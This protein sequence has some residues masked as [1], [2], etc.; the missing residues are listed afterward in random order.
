ME[1]TSYLLEEEE[2]LEACLSAIEPEEM[3]CHDLLVQ[4]F[5]VSMTQEDFAR[6]SGLIKASFPQAKVIGGKVDVCISGGRGSSNGISLTFMKFMSSEAN[7][8]VLHLDDEERAIEEDACMA[9]LEKQEDLAAIQVLTIGHISAMS[10]LFGGKIL[11][12]LFG[13][14]LGDSIGGK[15]GFIYC[16]GEVLKH[17]LLLVALC[18]PKLRVQVERS[19]GWQPLGPLMTITRVNGPYIVSELDG[20]P[21]EVMYDHYIGSVAGETFLD[22]SLLFPIVLH[23][24]S[25][26]I[27]RH[28]LRCREDGSAE[29]GAGFAVGDLV[30]FGYGNPQHV[31]YDT[32]EMQQRIAEFHP[33][34]L[35]LADCLAR[36]LLMEGNVESELKNC[37]LIAPSFGFYGYGELM[38]GRSSMILH[39]MTLVLTGI[40][41]EDTEELRPKARFV[42]DHIPLTR[43]QQYLSHLV[44]FVQQTTS[45]LEALNGLLGHKAQT[46][47]LT[48]L[49]N[50]GQIESLLQEI[51]KQE[52]RSPRGVCL[53]MIDAD[54]FKHINDHFGHDT[55]DVALKTIADV[56]KE[57]VR[58]SDAV[59]RWGGDEFWVILRETDGEGAAHVAARIKAGLAAYH[60]PDGTKYSLSIGIAAAIKGDTQETFFRRADQALYQAKRTPGKNATVVI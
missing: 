45:E 15:E 48:G 5:S 28:P 13:G 55:G 39:N 53:M 37:R 29:F 46:D 36:W 19:S 23:R 42:P 9:W 30:Q 54:N 1:V 41:E 4:I 31:I 43:Q 40:R 12:P 38:H 35:F 58:T 24:E 8:C 14:L 10:E 57:Q 16:D 21:F 49:Y 18:G 44:H 50:K 56:L 20:Q 47:A 17:G 59:G 33:Q 11:V 27:A 26:L 22:K 6:V 2:E 7:L 32:Q 60:L 25:G 51:M 3:E 52:A 34:G